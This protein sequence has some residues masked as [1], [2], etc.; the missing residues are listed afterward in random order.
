MSLES[1]DHR[2]VQSTEYAE[3]VWTSTPCTG[4]GDNS[5]PRDTPNAS[6]LIIRSTPYIRYVAELAQY[7]QSD[8]VVPRSMIRT[9]YHDSCHPRSIRVHLPFPDFR[10]VTD[11]CLGRRPRNGGSWAGVRL[12]AHSPPRAN[13]GEYWSNT[14]NYE[15]WRV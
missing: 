6:L 2:H 13:T 14:A 11:S 8:I 10:L 4:A 15:I 12:V 3:Y 1:C 9:E 5:P 7:I